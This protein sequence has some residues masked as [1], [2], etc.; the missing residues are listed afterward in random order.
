[1][2]LSNGTV[3][4]MIMD[5]DACLFNHDYIKF[6]F[7]IEHPKLL[8]HRVR[9]DKRV[10]H[11][12]LG[13]KWL[14]HAW[15][16]N[17]VQTFEVTGK[18]DIA[19]LNALLEDKRVK[20]KPKKELKLIWEERLRK[21]AKR[22]GIPRHNDVIKSNQK[23]L[24]QLKVDNE[25]YDESVLF[26]GSSRQDNE[27]NNDNCLHW[28]TESWFA[29]LVKIKNYLSN[30]GKEVKLNKL[31]L[32]DIYNNLKPGTCFDNALNKNYTGKHGKYKYY[33]KEKIT[34]LYLYMQVLA[35]TYPNK[36][37]T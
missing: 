33:D 17:R 31:M 16:D 15:K 10:L 13:N 32:S 8:A 24:D 35:I 23:F 5:G 25:Q 37:I 21:I 9:D 22:C 26:N 30:G 36:T 19:Y 29:A 34:T 6:H 7:I 2:A 4:A 14:L 3:H 1:M 28:G 27:Y 12:K 18:D 20:E 11:Q